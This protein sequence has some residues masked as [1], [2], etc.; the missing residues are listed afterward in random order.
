[1]FTMTATKSSTCP[2]SGL[3]IEPGDTIT[4]A[5][6]KYTPWSLT[7][8][9]IDRKQRVARSMPTPAPKPSG[10][11]PECAAPIYAE[12]VYCGMCGYRLAGTVTD[13]YT[14][15]TD[16]ERPT[17]IAEVR[18]I[19]ATPR[20]YAML[21]TEAQATPF[22]VAAPDTT[23]KPIAPQKQP[24]SR[25]DGNRPADPDPMYTDLITK[26]TAD[27]LTATCKRVRESARQL[28]ADRKEA[29]KG[30]G[31]RT[32]WEM[33]EDDARRQIAEAVR[34]LVL[35]DGSILTGGLLH[36]TYDAIPAGAHAHPIDAIIMADE[37]KHMADAL[38]WASKQ[39][40]H[41]ARLSV[42]DKYLVFETAATGG[43]WDRMRFASAFGH[44]GNSTRTEWPVRQKEQQA[45]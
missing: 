44:D 10:I 11:C 20:R 13:A 5:G 19:D 43:R 35:P 38:T 24:E 8:S 2:V 3:T 29:R 1:M 9:E 14:V 25:T 21:G 40:C 17:V 31:K 42:Q 12:D 7:K 32:R 16:D 27:A 30:K 36:D 28:E 33:Q 34:I 41:R 18:H 37:A 6:N 4:R 23:P 45:A 22:Q 26:L 39:K 15:A